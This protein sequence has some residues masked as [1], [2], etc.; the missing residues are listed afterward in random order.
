MS[1]DDESA[2]SRSFAAHPTFP[3]SKAMSA[4]INENG[5]AKGIYYVWSWALIVVIVCGIY[6]LNRAPGGRT[7]ESR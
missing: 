4:M 3:L 5:R 2:A 1:V 7:D 6:L